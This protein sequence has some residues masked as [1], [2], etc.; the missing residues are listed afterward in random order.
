MHATKVG[1]S[2]MGTVKTGGDLRDGSAKKRAEFLLLNKGLTKM[3]QVGGMAK[4][5]MM[6]GW[7]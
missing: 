7:W 5:K 2:K 4:A 3:Q 1:A 6:A